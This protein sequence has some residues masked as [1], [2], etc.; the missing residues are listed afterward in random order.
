[1]F[2]W[3][4]GLQDVLSRCGKSGCLFL[5]YLDVAAE[6]GAKIDFLDILNKS[7][8]NGYV[9]QDFTVMDANNL[10]LLATGKMWSVNR[11]IGKKYMTLDRRWYTVV[12]DIDSYVP[13]A[14]SYVVKGYGL[15]KVVG[16]WDRDRWHPL[17]DSNNVKNGHLIEIRLCSL[18]V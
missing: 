5:D 11:L 14:G 17:L 13:E 9:D 7:I 15:E 6:S 12:E 2:L 10:L 16:H 4:N 18:K 1:M 3:N 8:Q